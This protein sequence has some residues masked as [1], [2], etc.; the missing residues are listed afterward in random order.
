MKFY[1]LVRKT[2]L[3]TDDMLS[4]NVGCDVYVKREDLQPVHSFKLRGALHK[5]LK[6]PKSQLKRGVIAASAGNHAQGVALAA[7][8]L[9]CQATIVMPT[10]TPDVKVQ[11][12]RNYGAEVI[13]YGDNY[14]EAA[15]RC[16]ELVSETGKTFVHPFDDVDVITGQGTVAEEILEQMPGVTHIFVPIGG[17]G[18]LAG[19]LQVLRE[20]A[21][22]VKVIGVE[23]ADSAAMQLSLETGKRAVLG[24]VGVF[25]DGAAVAQV[26]ERTFAAAASAGELI[27]VDDDEICV[28][29]AGFVQEHRA[30]LEPAGALSLAGVRAYAE[31]H[32]FNASDRVVAICSGANIDNARLSYA[33]KRAEL[34]TEHTLLVRIQLPEEPGALRLL[35]QQVINGHNITSFTYRKDSDSPDAHIVIGLH[36]RTMPDRQLIARQLKKRHYVYTDLSSSDVIREHGVYPHGNVPD[37]AN[38]LFY[39]IEFADRP[40]ALLDLLANLGENWNISLFHYGGSA[41][42]TGRVLIGF[43]GAARM[44]LEPILRKHTR[45]YI[46][47]N[48]DVLTMYS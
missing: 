46:P 39:A 38:E 15:E 31:L 24:H 27:T 42:D 25:A 35:C 13:L 17:G 18:L 6:L 9:G 40:G 1:D 12:V 26:G 30:T 33:L 8:E 20:A 4:R 47:A 11:A 10:T 14:S 28:A 23:P 43:E 29:L 41:G 22:H 21:A 2:P 48:D 7:R 16:T 45:S 5:M 19:T 44:D 36:V 3:E 34:A 32:G 37:L